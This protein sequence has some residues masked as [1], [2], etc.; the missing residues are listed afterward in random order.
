MALSVRQQFEALWNS[1]L[2]FAQVYQSEYSG[3]QKLYDKPIP[4]PE[5]NTRVLPPQDPNSWRIRDNVNYF[6]QGGAATEEDKTRAR[7]AR[8]G[9]RISQPEGGPPV[10]PPEEDKRFNA[11]SGDMSI[12][13]YAN[14]NQDDSIDTLMITFPQLFRRLIDGSYSN[15]EAISLHN[16]AVKESSATIIY[17]E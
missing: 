15:A 14:D 9:I 17:W 6:W 5:V 8:Y 11:A 13:F 3:K 2:Q 10:P 7:D 4:V 16:E 1:P 12:G